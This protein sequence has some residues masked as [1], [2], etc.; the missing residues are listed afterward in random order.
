MTEPSRELVAEF[1]RALR[2]EPYPTDV[3]PYVFCRTHGQPWDKGCRAAVDAAQLAM[4]R[5]DEAKALTW[6]DAATA[7]SDHAD[8]WEEGGGDPC[9]VRVCRDMA[10]AFSAYGTGEGQ[11]ARTTLIRNRDKARSERDAA[12]AKN[13]TLRIENHSL[14]SERDAALE[15]IERVRALLGQWE[16]ERLN[17]PAYGSS[18]WRIA[19]EAVRTCE[20]ELRAA[21]DGDG[22]S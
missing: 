10:Q 16:Q 15:A 21:L 11:P 4:T 19:T 18:A 17:F 20:D 12:L 22:A 7:L 5:V 6:M 14:R 1:E 2:C 8:V 13:E 9:R 3:V